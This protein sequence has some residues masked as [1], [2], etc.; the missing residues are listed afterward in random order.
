MEKLWLTSTGVKKHLFSKLV[1]LNY[2]N[3]WC[4][5]GQVKRKINCSE[6]SVE[7]ILLE[8]SHMVKGRL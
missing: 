3:Y 1:A 7:L 8:L 6:L 4:H 5:A 2:K